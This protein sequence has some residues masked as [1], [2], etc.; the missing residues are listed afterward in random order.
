[1]PFAT[2]AP[3]VRVAIGAAMAE[4]DPQ[5]ELE[6]DLICPVC[7]AQFSAV[8]DTAT[9]FLQELDQRSARLLRDVHTLA[10]HYHWSEREIL[11]MAPQ[12]RAQYLDLVAGTRAGATSR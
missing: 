9:F 11:R 2:L 8:F 12:R 6:L 3:E 1:M 5:A 4:H 10:W 7:G